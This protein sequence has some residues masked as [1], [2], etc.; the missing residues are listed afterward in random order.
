MKS[1][2]QQVRDDQKE[3]EK[4]MDRL[5]EALNDLTHAM[6]VLTKEHYGRPTGSTGISNSQ[7]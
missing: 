6:L 1:L 4:R 3:T 2:L 7:N 5:E